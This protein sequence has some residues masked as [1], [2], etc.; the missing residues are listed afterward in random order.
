MPAKIQAME[1]MAE[2]EVI[3]MEDNEKVSGTASGRLM[4][5]SIIF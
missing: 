2:A 1:E 3:I 5:R 4:S